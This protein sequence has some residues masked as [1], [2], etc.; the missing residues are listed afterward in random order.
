MS[1]ANSVSLPG[2]IDTPSKIGDERA[3]AH[4]QQISL[5]HHTHTADVHILWQL[6]AAQGNAK[7]M[8]PWCVQK[9]SLLA[10]VKVKQRMH[11]QR[12]S[13]VFL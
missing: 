5:C 12:P 13:P 7:D 8:W 2:G 11:T 3:P 10:R 1:F 4:K 9:R 6:L